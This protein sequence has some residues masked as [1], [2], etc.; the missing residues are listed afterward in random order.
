MLFHRFL[1]RRRAEK[2]ASSAASALYLALV[3]QSRQP[4]FY[5]DHGVPDVLE[6]RYDM[7]ILHAWLVLRRLGD[8]VPDAQKDL[9]GALSQAVYDLMFADMDRNLREMGVGD[10]G[11][12]KRIRRMAEAFYGRVNAYDTALA[13]QGD[14]SQALARN[15]YQKNTPDAAQLALMQSYVRAQIDHL[16][17]LALSELLQG[18][19]SF[20]PVPVMSGGDAK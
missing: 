1:Q 11:V 18:R 9:A 5:V 16:Q 14:L 15:L 19:V 20:A 7:I 10:L 3:N 6:G 17:G 2:T 12:G 13:G 4:V 8:R